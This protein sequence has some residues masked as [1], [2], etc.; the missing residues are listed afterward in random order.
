MNFFSRGLWKSNTSKRLTLN[1]GSISSKV[2]FK[3]VI[4]SVPSDEIDA[5]RGEDYEK[6]YRDVSLVEHFDQF[7]SSS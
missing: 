7:L 3:E 2:L 1:R 6:R 4:V 5:S